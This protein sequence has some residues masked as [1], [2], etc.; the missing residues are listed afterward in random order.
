M[1]FVMA[2]WCVPSLVRA[3]DGRSSAAAQQAAF[4]ARQSVAPPSAGR[5]VS[6]FYR[7]LQAFHTRAQVQYD[8]Q[9]LR[10]QR[11]AL[12]TELTAL[13]SELEVIEEDRQELKAQLAAIEREQE[14]RLAL[15]RKNLEGRLQ[16]ELLKTGAQLQD[17]LR[18]DGARQV[19]TFDARQG[20]LVAR[21]IDHELQ[22]KERDLDQLAQEIELQ[23]QEVRSYFTR[24]GDDPAPA[25]ALEQSLKNALVRRRQQLMGERERLQ[26]ER[27]G[28]LAQRRQAFLAKLRQ[29]QEG[30]HRRRL[31][32]KEA[33]FRQGMADLLY[34]A[35]VQATAERDHLERALDAA[36]KRY[37]EAATRQ[38]DAQNRMRRSDQ[39]LAA[40]LDRAK[41]VELEWEDAVHRLELALDES[42]LN[43]H[44]ELL[45]WFNETADSLAPELASELRVLPP[46]VMSRAE[47]ERE[48]EEQRRVLRERQLALQL[49]RE[50][51]AHHERLRLK[52]E[53]ERQAKA[54]KADQL[55]EKARRLAERAAYDEALQALLEAQAL[56]PP[57]LE[58]VLIAREEILAAKERA[59]RQARAAE[60]EQMFSRAMKA[61][62]EGRF[63]DAIPLFE[64]V[65]ADEAVLE[66][67][68]P[69]A[70]AANVAAP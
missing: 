33:A 19:Q 35:R 2:L 41:T 67:S 12:N 5:V 22:L 4:Q 56:D 3:E 46:R 32:L 16:E 68:P 62:E 51:E 38:G 47:Q 55:L 29:E 42:S 7:T 1:L 39:E 65:I 58:R 6:P 20:E 43:A 49:A 13:H 40:K 21:G 66:A 54:Q 18:E 24:L 15:L 26:A 59:A 9:K 8:I 64:K 10:A 17:E 57:Q 37:A 63:E 52:Q 34:K 53:E 28:L 27:Q 14:Q 50:M 44:P 45:V 69:E 60:L 30:E 31:T 25:Q 36:A 70:P 11:D 61:F 23:L 48:L